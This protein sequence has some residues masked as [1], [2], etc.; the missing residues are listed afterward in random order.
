[1]RDG[2]ESH[3]PSEEM[4]KYIHNTTLYWKT[5]ESLYPFLGLGKYS[6]PE[7]EKMKRITLPLN[8]HTILVVRIEIKIDHNI[9]IDKTLQLI[10]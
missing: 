8:A 2:T 10:N 7:Y 3:L 6:I 5:R 4:T 1:M 9:I